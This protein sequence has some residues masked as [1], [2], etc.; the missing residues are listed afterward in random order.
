MTTSVPNQQP[1]R[2]FQWY[3]AE[4]ELAVREEFPGGYVSELK[5]IHVGPQPDNLFV[6]PAGYERMQMPPQ[7]RPQGGSGR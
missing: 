5:N 6:V 4:L 7:D 1:M 2:T 3:D